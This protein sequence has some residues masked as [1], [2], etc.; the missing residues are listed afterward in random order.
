MT[1]KR[2]VIMAVAIFGCSTSVWSTGNPKVKYLGIEH[3]LSNNYVTTIFQDTYG[4]MW[5]GTADGVNRYDGYQ[6][7]VYKNQPDNPASL[8]DNRITD[9]IEDHH[10][11]IWVATKKGVSILDEKGSGFIHLRYKVAR[12]GDSALTDFAVSSMALGSEGDLFVAS[13]QAGLLR[14]SK[15]DAF[16]ASQIP[17]VHASGMQYNYHVQA[18]DIDPSGVLWLVIHDIGLCYRDAADGTIRLKSPYVRS[19]T[20]MKVDGEGRIWLGTDQGLYRYHIKEDQ[21][22]RYT[23][24]HGL[25]ANVIASLSLGRDQH[26]WVGTDGGGITVIDRDGHFGYFTGAEHN[27]VL[28]SGAVFAVYED[29]EA[30]HWIGTLR[31]GVNIIDP[32]TSRFK[33]VRHSG[34]Q[35]TVCDNDFIL[36]FAED[37]DG[38]L[39]IGTDGSGLVHWNRDN[40]TFAYYKHAADR[41]GSL[42]NNFVTSV[43]CDNQGDIWATTYGGGINRFNRH[44]GEFTRYACFNSQANYENRNVWKIYEDSQGRLWATTLLGGG[45]YL[46]NRDR[47]IFELYDATIQD[48]LSVTEDE[49]GVFWLGTFSALIKLDTRLRTV[50]R[51]PIAHSVRAIHS[52]HNDSLWV[53]T[54]GSGLLLVDKKTGHYRQLTESDGLPSNAILNLLQDSKG[55]FWLST[56]SGLCKFDPISDEICNFYESDGLQSNQFNYNAALKLRSGEFVFGGIKGFN[57]FFPDSIR[58]FHTVPKLVL[59]DLRINNKSYERYPK[60]NGVGNVLNASG[61]EVP[62]SDA[63]LSFSFSA[64][65]YSSPDKIKYAYMLEGWDKDWNYV[66]GQRTAHYSRLNEGNYTLRIKSTN[67]DGVW[68]PHERTLSVHV[69]PPWWR[70]RW[71]YGIYLLLGMASVYGYVYYDRRQTKLS[72][73]VELARMEVKK[74]KELNEKKLAFFTHISH[75]FRTPLT[76]IVNP[77]KELLYSENKVVDSEELAM[78]YRNSKRL[79]GLVDQLLLF[80]KADSGEDRL[81]LVRLNMVTLCRE[82]FFSFKQHAE[83]RRIDYRF[84]CADEAMVL[85]ADREKMEIVLFNLISNALKFTPEGGE[86]I[87]ALQWGNGDMCVTVSDTGCGVP[88]DLADRVFDSF[89]RD[90]ASNGSGVS[91]FGIGLF[92]VKKFVEAHAGTIGYTSTDGRGTRFTV[93][94]RQGRQHFENQYVFEDVGEHSMFLD[95]LMPESENLSTATDKMAKDEMKEISE[96]VTDSPVML[97]IDDNTQIRHY[98]QRIFN[99]RCMVYHAATGEEGLR[100]AKKYQPDIVLCDVVMGDLSGI[101]LCTHIKHDPVMS[102]IPV[103]LLTASS[104]EEVKLKGIECGA[105]DYITKPFDKELLVARVSGVLKSRS[106]LQQYFFNEVTLRSQ[107]FKISSEYTDFLNTCIATVEKHLDNP[108][109]NVKILADEVGMSH[110]NLYK[111]IKSISGKSANE[112]I[113]FIRLRKVA[114]LLISTDCNVSEAAYAAGF[115]DIKYFREQFFKLF[116]TKPSDYKKRFRDTFRRSYNVKRT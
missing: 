49:A 53:G 62:Y 30:R 42:S 65:E 22:N 79:L 109:F 44:T 16:L 4:F 105:D 106:Q 96:L 58:N 18:M 112:F 23:R 116:G 99:G 9:V 45:L 26:L 107:D 35:Y 33:L 68:S 81:R 111:K 91:G 67:A 19:V 21:Y 51:I 100:L 93:T 7:K 114:Q 50:S 2:W 24:Q 28:T 17:Y 31:G 78:V 76:L 34:Q 64:L 12:S 102:H 11:S 75:E 8:L 73:E 80:R 56:F 13:E 63:V 10:G 52:G 108:D 104:S 83:S 1:L 86:V 74:E 88:A 6:F 59:T 25:S 110:S 113:R 37:D 39:W 77:I 5:F 32:K 60:M 47:N 92:L 41:P 61:L 57:L 36:S 20:C 69:L 40:N 48:V 85:F 27:G 72:Y 43:I 15:N 54:E 46:F 97:V 29:A 115:N 66:D 101:D 103:I 87:V 89:Y 82:V 90:S 71:A 55:N 38:T 94:L 84:E 98:I 14:V 95:E 70:T 3:G